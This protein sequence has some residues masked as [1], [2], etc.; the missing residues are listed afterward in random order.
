MGGAYALVC[1]NGVSSSSR[2]Y[3][4]LRRGEDEH[5]TSKPKARGPDG[6]PRAVMPAHHTLICRSDP[7]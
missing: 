6:A 7:Y 2:C 1:E 5:T 4:V 3:I